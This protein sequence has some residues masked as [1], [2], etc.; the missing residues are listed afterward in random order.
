LRRTGLLAILAAIGMAFGFANHWLI[1]YFFGASRGADIFFG[2]NIVLLFVVGLVSG[3]IGNTIVPVLSVVD[4][5]AQRRIDASTLLAAV[6]FVFGGTAVLAI[7]LAGVWVP[8]ALPGFE[9]EEQAT[10]IRFARIQLIGVVFAAQYGVLWATAQ[11]QRKFVTTELMF[12]IAFLVMVIAM[13]LTAPTFGIEAMAWIAAVRPAVQAVLL[14]PLIGGLRRPDFASEAL[15]ETWRRVRPLLAG[16]LYYKSDV[17]ADRYLTS[18]APA[19][20]LSLFHVATVM[21]RAATGILNRVFVGPIVPH[22]A[23]LAKAER[24][25]ELTRVYR[26][27]VLFLGALIVIGYAVVW[28]FG[29][30]LLGLLIGYGGVTDEN[31][32]TLYSIILALVGLSIGLVGQVLASTFYALADTKTP[33]TASIIGF[34]CGLGFKILGFYWGGV[35]GLALGTS[36]YFL[37][38][39]I[40]LTSLLELRL[41]KL[42]AAAS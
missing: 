12:V 21:Y 15:K 7:L 18:M 2:S 14:V 39:L 25:T 19:G 33:T 42:R 11:A 5:E 10:A 32:R 40:L 26:K 36:A 1:L 31:V 27:R 23:T 28:L 38:N 6:T 17:F 29:E 20:A 16:S 9:G 37:L 13:W 35:V 3:P 22:L 41:A 4:D 8:I 34:T 30:T 24:Y